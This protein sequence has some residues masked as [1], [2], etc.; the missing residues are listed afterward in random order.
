MLG[1]KPPQL[2]GEI[3]HSQDRHKPPAQAKQVI[4]SRYSCTFTKEG[5][6]SLGNHIGIIHFSMESALKVLFAVFGG[7]FGPKLEPEIV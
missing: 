5:P 7:L 6:S 4:K 3:F 2:R 1:L